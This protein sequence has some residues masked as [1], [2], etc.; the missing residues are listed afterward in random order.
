MIYTLKFTQAAK[1]DVQEA[2]LWYEEKQSGL[3]DDFVLS[4]EA[5]VNQITRNPLLFERKFNS[6]HIAPLKRFPYKTI[7]AIERDEIIVIAVFHTSRNPTIW[8]ERADD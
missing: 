4:V 2:W 7:Y 5:V 6:L 8:L 3:G 1:L